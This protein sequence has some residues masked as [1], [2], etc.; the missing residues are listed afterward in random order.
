MV[1]PFHGL[2]TFIFLALF[3]PQ[4]IGEE[5]ELVSD[6]EAKGTYKSGAPDAWR[7]CPKTGVYTKEAP[8][9]NK[10]AS[11]ENQ[12]PL[13]LEY[14]HHLRYIFERDGKRWRRAPARVVWEAEHAYGRFVSARNYIHVSPKRF[15]FREGTSQEGKTFPWKEYG[16]KLAESFSVDYVEANNSYDGEGG[17]KFEK[18]FVNKNNPNKKIS[19]IAKLEHALFDR[20]VGDLALT[21]MLFTDA[22]GDTFRIIFQLVGS[23]FLCYEGDPSA[24][25]QNMPWLVLDSEPPDDPIAGQPRK[26]SEHPIQRASLYWGVIV[27]DGQDFQYTNDKPQIFLMSIDNL[28][29]YEPTTIDAAL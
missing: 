20:D 5:A 21:T 8:H 17:V 7:A 2:L 14:A 9:Y 3:V 24:I 11:D 6:M 4:A 28:I 25:K 13:L 22:N 12:Q 15:A 18:E 10:Y 26:F 27:K 1:G 16:A 29:S 19:L 23:N